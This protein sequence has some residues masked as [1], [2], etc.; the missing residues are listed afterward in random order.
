MRVLALR[1]AAARSPSCP[2][3]RHPVKR[4]DKHVTLVNLHCKCLQQQDPSPSHTNPTPV[5]PA[6]SHPRPQRPPGGYNI[7]TTHSMHAEVDHYRVHWWECGLCG[8]TIKRSMNR[9]PQEADC[10][11][12]GRGDGDKRR[13]LGGADRVIAT[14]CSARGP[15]DAPAAPGDAAQTAIE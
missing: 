1:T 6:C 14:S 5:A 11:R 13:R 4:C 8:H 2:A 3:C 12:C 9:P 7:T 15:A 10:I